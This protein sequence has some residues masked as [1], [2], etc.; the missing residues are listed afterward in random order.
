MR[1]LATPPAPGAPW[2][3]T[4]ALVAFTLAGVAL[5]LSQG[6]FGRLGCT[7]LAAAGLGFGGAG[8]LVPPRRPVLPAAASALNVGVLGLAVLLPGWLGVGAWWPAAPADDSRAVKAVGIDGATATQAEWVDASKA[9]WQRDGVRVSISSASVGPVDLV[10]PNK[11]RDRTKA[12]FLRL[13]LR[14]RNE[15]V[16][17]M[18]EF[19]GW[20]SQTGAAA[21]K[22]TDSTGKV[23]ALKTFEPNWQP[24][25]R[26]TATTL[27]PGKS[28]E[29]FLVF[30]LPAKN[31]EYL[32]L[33][34]PGAA[35]G[36]A[37]PVKLQFPRS[38]IVEL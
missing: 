24:D 15:G 29:D 11:K 13:R 34:L 16:G 37:E 33:E 21:P 6:P 26:A 32:R 5:V 28:A 19:S 3:L 2:S 4:L 20:S 17:R 27:F 12:K 35:F 23:I 36:D 25:G 18:V 38:W 1:T 22:L 30:E 31:V 10:G 7:C 9:A 8:C 14:L